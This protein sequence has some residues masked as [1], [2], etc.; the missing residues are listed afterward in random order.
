VAG[1]HQLEEKA[2]LFLQQ[3]SA[4]ID[5]GVFHNDVISVGHLNVLLVHELAFADPSATSQIRECF[6]RHCGEELIVISATAE[7]LPLDDV[8][9]SYLFNSQLVSLPDG[10]MSLIAPRECAEYEPARR[11]IDETIAG[12]NPIRSVHYVD[13]RQS[14]RNGGGPACLRLRVALMDR[15][16]AGTHAGVFLTPELY[17]DLVGW[18]GRHY[19]DQLAS[20]DLTDPLLLEESRRALDELTKLLQLGS[21]YRFQR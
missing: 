2:A 9:R 16:M 13:V 3:N 17:D 21:M 10:S 4:A 15:E 18:V 19:R 7:Q 20:N 11:F 8:V 12:G 1:L 5:A 6:L 14:M